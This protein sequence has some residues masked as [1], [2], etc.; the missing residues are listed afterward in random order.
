MVVNIGVTLWKLEILVNVASKVRWP[1]SIVCDLYWL[2]LSCLWVLFFYEA[3]HSIKQPPI[4]INISFTYITYLSIFFSYHLYL[5]VAWRT[6]FGCSKG[7]FYHLFLTFIV[8]LC[9]LLAR[10]VLVFIYTNRYISKTFWIVKSNSISEISDYLVLKLPTIFNK[11]IILCILLF[12]KNQLNK[13]EFSNTKLS[14]SLSIWQ[15]YGLSNFSQIAY[16]RY[17]RKLFNW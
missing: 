7:H 4:T 12:N 14:T 11:N 2:S 6:M 9:L 3:A 10:G 1:V 16:K 15:S 8:V 13:I 5:F 17:T